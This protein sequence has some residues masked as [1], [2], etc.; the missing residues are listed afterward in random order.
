MRNFESKVSNEICNNVWENK[1]SQA[2]YEKNEGMKWAKNYPKP[3]KRVSN[4]N[5]LL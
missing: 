3:L 5:L 2:L 1:T 4:S